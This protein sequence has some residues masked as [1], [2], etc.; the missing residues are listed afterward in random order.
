VLSG[1][2]AAAAAMGEL[3]LGPP[4]GEGMAGVR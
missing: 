4:V 2:A 1:H 3:S